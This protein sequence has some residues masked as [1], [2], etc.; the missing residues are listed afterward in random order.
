MSSGLPPVGG[1]PP[2]DPSQYPKESRVVE[3]VSTSLPASVGEATSQADVAA[4]IESLKGSQLPENLDKA[5][6]NI[7]NGNLSGAAIAIDITNNTHSN[8][9]ISIEAL[10]A[11]IAIIMSMSIRR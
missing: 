7:D 2:I 6:S 4:N 8:L 1:E 5:V 9:P 10:A 3:Q 11:G